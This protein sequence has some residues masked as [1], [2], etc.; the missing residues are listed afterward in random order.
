V[1]VLLHLNLFWLVQLFGWGPDRIWRSLDELLGRKLVALFGCKGERS[2]F[3]SMKYVRYC[4][5][6]L[7]RIQGPVWLCN[8]FRSVVS[9]YSDS[10]A[11][12]DMTHKNRVRPKLA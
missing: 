5:H 3:V 4:W 8:S 12:S 7:S 9:P 1:I 11:G 2:C 10:R 6:V